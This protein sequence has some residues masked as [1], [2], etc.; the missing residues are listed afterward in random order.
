[1]TRN[2]QCIL[3]KNVFQSNRLLVFTHKS[4]RHREHSGQSE[5]CAML[6]MT[7][8]TR[9]VQLPESVQGLAV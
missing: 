4:V 2:L 3:H 1:M 6:S 5:R 7:F 8:M 9:G